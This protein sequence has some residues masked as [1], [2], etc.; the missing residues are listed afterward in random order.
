MPAFKTIHT[1]YGLQRLDA[2]EATGVPINLTHMAV[3]D[4]N[5]NPVTPTEAQTELVR[6]LFRATVNRV[7]QDA[8]NPK[9]FS[10]ELI[11]PAGVGGFT[12]RE[13]GV[14]DAGG[15]LFVVGNLPETYK[16]EITDGSYSDTVVRVDFLV[17][18]ASAVTIMV[19][20]NVVL[21]TQSWVMNNVTAAFLMPGGTTG[22]VWTKDSN[23]D[24]D[25]SWQDAD[26][27]NV[28][29][30]TIEEPQ[31]LVAAQTVVTL[32][33][34]TT[35]GLAVY[36]DGLRIQKGAGA[37]KW[38][39]DATFPAT[40][41]VL[42]TAATAGQKF[43]GVQ[44]EPT[45]SVPFPLQRDL[46]L[47]DVPDKALGRTNLGVYSKAETDTKAPPGTVVH[48]AG[49][50]APTGW[51]ACNGGAVNRVAYA[52]L[53]AAIGTTYGVGDG[54]TSF[55]VPDLRGEFI[56]GVDGGRGV[57][58]GRALGSAQAAAFASH[59]HT[60]SVTQHD[61]HAHTG[62]TDPQGAHSHTGN[63]DGQGYHSHT[64][65]TNLAG[66]HQHQFPNSGKS[67]QVGFASAAGDN[68]VNGYSLTELAGDHGHSFNTD[69]SGTHSHNIGTNT[70][71]AHAHNVNTNLGGVHA[72]Q[73]DVNAT[74]GNETRPRNVALLAIIKF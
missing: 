23:A 29:V 71:A 46:N 26:V 53:F 34:V 48:F 14:F 72:H 52:A 8:V 62:G 13:V 61:G 68:V 5:G 33:T 24:G 18:N 42:G 50:V 2:A 1:N 7:Y 40:K 60:T 47:S 3:G 45:G 31:A 16:P 58:I 22:Q 63:T 69:G 73:V 11:I 51:L 20:P 44:N 38:L 17:N 25:A 32:A 27:A 36:V 15:S 39:P 41:V 64:G 37:G 21:V 12:L 35:H 67:D 66:N 70:V 55:N 9:K 43:L 56:R 30:D 6:E 65:T 10:A 57:D 74:G 28:V 54:F 4:G 49:S 59:A 19:D